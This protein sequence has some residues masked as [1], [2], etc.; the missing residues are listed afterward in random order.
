[1]GARRVVGVVQKESVMN[2]VRYI[3]ALILVMS[4]I[5]GLLFW[6]LI[7]PFVRFWR[8]IG[9]GWTYSVVSTLLTLVTVGLFLVRKPLLAIEFGTSYP[10]VVVGVLCLAVAA[11]RDVGM[12]F[13]VLEQTGALHTVVADTHV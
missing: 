6:L 11:S 5:P 12:R 2:A 10:L 7:H 3:L 9:P 13:K 1:V 8:Q 4:L